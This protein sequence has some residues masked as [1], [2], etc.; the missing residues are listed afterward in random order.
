MAKVRLAVNKNGGK[1]TGD[2]FYNLFSNKTADERVAIAT[3]A[4]LKQRQVTTSRRGKPTVIWT[5]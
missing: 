4:G 5:W 2:E 3:A 1:L